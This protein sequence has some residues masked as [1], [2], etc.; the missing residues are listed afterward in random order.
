MGTFRNI[1]AG[2][3]GLAAVTLAAGAA[4]A[5]PVGPGALAAGPDA[6]PIEN[7]QFYGP[8]YGYYGGPR[9]FYGPRPYY[10]YGGPGYG[11]GPGYGRRVVCRFRPTPY[12]PRRV[13][14]RRY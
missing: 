12:G 5:A 4:N 7:A 3:I 1:V 10:G 14:F 9:P 13:C 2:G 8:G 11:Y 6:A